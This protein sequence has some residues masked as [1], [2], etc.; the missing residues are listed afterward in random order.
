MFRIFKALLILSFISLMTVLFVKY[1][2]TVSDLFAS[3]L[4]FLPTGWAILLIGQA[5]GPM[6]RS[7][8]CWELIMELARAYEE[9]MGLLVFMPIAILSWFPSVSEIQTRLL[10]HQAFCRGLTFLRS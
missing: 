10:Y 2:V 7:S 8:G 3:I 6:M 4:V 1:G 9:I 5:L